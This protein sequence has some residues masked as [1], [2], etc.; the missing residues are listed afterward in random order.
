MPH[1]Q[2][3]TLI[4]FHL[5][6]STLHFCPRAQLCRHVASFLCRP[7]D[8]SLAILRCSIGSVLAHEIFI[9]NNFMRMH[10]WWCF[11]LIHLIQSMLQKFPQPHLQYIFALVFE[12]VLV[13]HLLVKHVWK[14]YCFLPYSWWYGRNSPWNFRTISFKIC[15]HLPSCLVW[16]LLMSWSFSLIMH[17][18]FKNW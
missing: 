9:A 4:F 6:L 1:G 8:V 17:A 5:C 7:V 18:L 12:W 11:W 15:C 13:K 14:R 2:V 3:Y 16:G 10:M